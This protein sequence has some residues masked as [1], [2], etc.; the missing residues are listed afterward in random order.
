MKA[1]PLFM[2]AVCAAVLAGCAVSTPPRELVEARHA[3]ERASAGQAARLVRRELRVAK[4][5]LT[6]AERSFDEEQSTE[7]TCG[8]ASVATAKARLADSLATAA[9]ARVLDAKAARDEAAIASALPSRPSVILPAASRGKT[10]AT[11]APGADHVAQVDAENRDFDD[12]KNLEPLASVREDS[13][14]LV[15]T[16]WGSVLFP[17]NEASLLSPAQERLNRLAA[18]LLTNRERRLTVEGHMDSWGASVHNQELSQQRADAV[19]TFFVSRGYPGNLIHARG[20]GDEKPVA[21]NERAEGRANNQRVE[22]VVARK[23]Q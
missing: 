10:S 8:L 17:S 4:T 5:A 11:R 14:G 22:I 1:N 15:L 12:Y 9:I 6:L 20:L 2:V 19:R 16:I 21:D 18:V 3:Y 7:R 23:S 13:R